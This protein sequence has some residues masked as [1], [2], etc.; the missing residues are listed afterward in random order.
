M[1]YSLAR[2]GFLYAWEFDE[3]AGAWRCR[4]EACRVVSC[5]VVLG[6]RGVRNGPLPVV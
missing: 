2:D 5:R 1:V 6:D 4:Y 3:G